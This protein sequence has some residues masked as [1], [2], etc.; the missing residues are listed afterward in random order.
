MNQNIA[1]WFGVACALAVA[2]ACGGL[3]SSDPLTNEG[4]GA[5]ESA[6]RKGLPGAVN[7]AI[8]YCN[9][10]AALCVG[11]EG[12]CDADSQCV[13]GLVCGVDNGPNF[14]MILN[15]D[16]CVPPHCENG[17]LDADETVTDCGGADC[18]TFCANVCASLPPNGTVDHCTLGCPCPA[19]EGDCDGD[20]QCQSGLV[21]GADNGPSFGMGNAYDVC[22]VPHCENGVRD[23][24][25][26]ITDCGG[27]DCGSICD[28][29]C[30]ALPVNGQLGHCSADCPCPATEG[31]CNADSEC[32]SGLVCGADNGPS[33]GLDHAYDVCVV[34]HCNNRVRD[35]DETATDCGGADCGWICADECAAVP[36]NG[37]I[38][39]CTAACPCAAG[40]T[41][42]NLDSECAGG[43]TCGQDIG[44]F[45]GY[46]RSY[47]V[48]LASTCGNSTQDGDETGVDCGGSCS[49][50]SGGHIS[51]VGYGGANVDAVR[52]VVQDTLGNIIIAGRYYVNTNLGGAD[53]D[54]TGT[55]PTAA[56]IFIAKYT[57]NGQ[58]IWSKNFGSPVSDGDR[59][60]ALATDSN[61]AIYIA[62]DFQ[63]SVDFGGGPLTATNGSDMFLVKL[64][65]SGSHLWSQR[66]GIGNVDRVDG[67]TVD[68]LQN[69]YLVGAF[70]DS[71]TFGGG[72]L[73]SVGGSDVAVA[74]FSSAGAHVWSKSFGSTGN[75]VAQAITVDWASYS[76]VTGSFSGTM[77][78]GNSTLTS[79]GSQDVFLVQY[80]G[81][82]AVSVAK[83]MGG[84]GA[85]VGYSVSVDLSR[86]P[87]VA[88]SF[89][90]S[91]DFGG[92]T[93]INGLGFLD[94]FVAAYGANGSFRWAKAVGSA[95]GN[96]VI[97][98]VSV[99]YATGFV[100]ATGYASG[101]IPAFYPNASDATSAGGQDAIFLGYSS[102]GTLVWSRA[103]GSSGTDYGA[104]A[105]IF[106]N[107]AVFAGAYGA[108][109]SVGGGALPAVVGSRDVFISRYRM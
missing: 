20:A 54:A 87:V 98:G 41:D 46:G 53:L 90:G 80:N 65:G 69:V 56:E 27:V 39:H 68:R 58:H 32:Q 25:E 102:T 30:G 107:T 89:A 8:D 13:S 29:G 103:H 34:P 101:T 1:G 15:Y 82:G 77:N 19:R 51:S 6:L 37:A 43:G 108:A 42:C 50:C 45:Y 57:A 66:F 70:E 49:P 48:C 47:D 5:A 36:P 12:D 92:G 109:M 71:I 83:R 16:V 60:V 61:N 4:Y 64:D 78:V 96:D 17:V 23:A 88:G 3:S 75:D 100:V 104:A 14:G 22:V 18:G 73:T 94:G 86:G 105:S 67:I 26:T 10:P 7:G 2:S 35:V 44:F 59:D 106:Q 40:E 81:S 93:P 79:A 62:G 11:G 99:D 95:T 85:D 31:D 55:S 76:W 33:F 24:D 91:V 28:A 9:N 63:Q 97:Y 21:C 84:V 38:G 74:K 72:L 52:S